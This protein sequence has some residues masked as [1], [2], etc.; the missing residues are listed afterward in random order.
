MPWNDPCSYRLNVMSTRSDGDGMERRD[1]GDRPLLARLRARRRAWRRRAASTREA[2]DAFPMLTLGLDGDGVVTL[3]NPA[4]EAAIGLPS[5]ALLGRRFDELLTTSLRDVHFRAGAAPVERSLRGAAGERRID[6]RFVRAGQRTW[7]FGVDVTDA[8]ASERKLRV[9]EQLAVIA[10]L[11]TGL[12]HELR[13]PLN[14]AMLELEL[15]ARRLGR[16]ETRASRE[17]VASARREL[18]RIDRLLTEFLWFAR[19]GSS[20]TQP[21]R[22]STPT[23]AVV[24]LT[25]AETTARGIALRTDF[26][27]AERPVMF[28][29]DRIRQA[30][31]NLVRNAIEATPAGGNILLRVHPGERASELDVEDDG[32]GIAF[33]PTRAFDPFFTTRPHGVGLGLT[34]AQCIAA[35]HGGEIRVQS[36]PGRT[37]FTL[38]LPTLAA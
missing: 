10:D 14:S 11:T 13:N 2:V 37:V 18:G 6:W 15:V 5:E 21:G 17:G 3:V 23:G 20:T 8:R 7:A 38:S 16:A 24:R 29:E 34:V 27:P 19:P 22:L 32:P 33:E 30:I 12:A 35:D 28:D 1:G 26:D 9:A 36:A 31:F 4:V 25:S